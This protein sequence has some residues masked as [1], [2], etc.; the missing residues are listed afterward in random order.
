MKRIFFILVALFVCI[1]GFAQTPNDI[2]TEF[3]QAKKASF[4]NVPGYM[5]KLTHLNTAKYRADSLKVL[6]LGNCS[7]RVIKRF[8]KMTAH[9][10]AS[11][12]TPIA[13]KNDKKYY[14]SQVWLR[15]K[16][17][18]ISSILLLRVGKHIGDLIQIDGNL[19]PNSVSS[20]I[21]EDYDSL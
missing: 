11:G 3:C 15:Q 2:F 5:I 9:L 19:D 1:Y 21:D 12:Y 20:V 7:R 18:A 4:V 14:K 10:N 8:S 17:G 6:N 13:A 16:D